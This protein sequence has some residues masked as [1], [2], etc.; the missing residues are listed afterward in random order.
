[1]CDTI[2]CLPIPP[3]ESA[4]SM[5]APD[6][7]STYAEQLGT[8]PPTQ[9]EIDALLALAGEAAHASERMAAPVACWIAAKAGVAPEDAL[10]LA[11]RIAEVP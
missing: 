3:L 10:A 2:P 9:P 7:L 4:P 1:V 8:S 6:W 5:N 11:K